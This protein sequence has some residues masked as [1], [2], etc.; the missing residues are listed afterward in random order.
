VPVRFVRR[1]TIDLKEQNSTMK[2]SSFPT[3]MT[4]YFRLNLVILKL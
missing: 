3:F 2:I 4:T 1:F